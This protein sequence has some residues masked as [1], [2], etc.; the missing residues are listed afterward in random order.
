MAS[1]S[2]PSRASAEPSVIVRTVDGRRIVSRTNPEISYAYGA[3]ATS[4]SRRGG[5]GSRSGSRAGAAGSD[6]D[7][8]DMS[9][10]LIIEQSMSPPPASDPRARYQALKQRQQ[11]QKSPTKTAGVADARMSSRTRR[12]QA[13]L[14]SISEDRDDARSNGSRS[15]TSAQSAGRSRAGNG[16]FAGHFNSFY[17]DQPSDVLG[18]EPHDV[19]NGLPS[20]LLLGAQR[21]SS[22]LF[23]SGTGINSIHSSEAGDSR[24]HDY[25]EEARQA[26]LLA[27]NGGAQTR[28]LLTSFSPRSWFGARSQSGGERRA[29]VAFENDEDRD[30]LVSPHQASSARRRRNGRT[31]QDYLAYRPSEDDSDSDMSGEDRKHSRR[32]RR[33]SEGTR[34]AMRGGRDDNK[35]WMSS[36]RK[37]RAKRRRDENGNIVDTGEDDSQDEERS[38][39]SDEEV[40]ELTESSLEA[41]Q[42]AL[43]QQPRKPFKRRRDGKM[44]MS[45]SSL[46]SVRPF[47]FA[48]AAAIA[49][50]YLYNH[51]P[52]T[53][54]LSD[55][56][57]GF[58]PRTGPQ[59]LADA[60]SRIVKLETAYEA[61]RE[62]TL[63]GNK[64]DALLAARIGSLE[65]NLNKATEGFV[66][67]RTAMEERVR[68]AERDSA[69]MH[70]ALEELRG[71]AAKAQGSGRDAAK[72]EVRGL[73]KRMQ[74][75]ESHIT[76]TD[77]RLA[78][79]T[80][81]ARAAQLLSD[82]VRAG[83]AEMERKLP[84]EIAVPVDKRTGAPILGASTLQ[85][86]KKVFVQK[87]DVPDMSW[88]TFAAGNAKS[89]RSMMSSVI[90]DESQAGTTIVGRSLFLE[91]LKEELD[92][93][94]ASMEA[95]FNDNAQEMQNDILGKV[96]AQQ[97]M[98]ERSG[99]WTKSGS[100]S[101]GDAPGT[102]PIVMKDGSDARSAILTLIDGALETYSADRIA[103]RDYALYTAGGRIIPSYTSPTY[104]LDAKQSSL[105]SR[106][107]GTSASSGASAKKGGLQRHASEGHPPVVALYPDNAPGM[108]WAFHGDEGQL[109]I[110]LSR[111]VV[112]SNITLEH[113]PAS[114]S[115]EAGTSAP[116]DVTVWGIVERPEDVRR[117]VAY[118]LTQTAP[119]SEDANS[120]E[121]G[122]TEAGGDG[123]QMTG[124]APAPMPPSERH[125]LLASLTYDALDGKS[126]AIQ[127]FAISHE[128]RFLQIPTAAVQVHVHSNHGNKEFTCLYRIRVHG[129]E[130]T[131]EDE[132]REASS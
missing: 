17:M 87:S 30:H 89:L 114:I 115:L 61:L 80:E 8:D 12:S 81:L 38:T 29:D 27:Q 59:S 112:V 121:D 64:E 97:D 37:R 45:S 66:T 101:R 91:L 24:S 55:L 63:G 128:A 16:A 54:G 34:Q 42:A 13:N 7:G 109:G 26:S 71:R 103:L 51:R 100:A 74:S 113:T 65:Q 49:G 86:L 127:T 60:A 130:W 88:D 123:L 118:R 21:P 83:L 117:L 124:V 19:T 129:R 56:P 106:F 76:A 35:I 20:A 40:E 10:P 104:R 68:K 25:A 28:S 14:D 111:R 46:S 85:E 48:A 95:R 53:M 9:P 67:S 11:Q 122:V 62:A 96:R 47:L 120:Q 39:L 69:R 15:R 119:A 82:R 78:E 70:Q 44:A 105:L 36:G 2:S 41:S 79:T 50:S 32:G 52:P 1:P 31:S 125:I 93:A 43:Q 23:A 116:R 99:S 102:Q 18:H 58:V 132:T 108:C 6:V 84:T 98:F 4:S 77:K 57:A 126:R 33:K 72:E 92:K 22:H 131:R 94:K 73:Q 107:L 5:A 90:A 3:P 110:S 75:L